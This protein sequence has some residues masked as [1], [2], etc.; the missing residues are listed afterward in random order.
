MKTLV[1]VV[2]V[3]VLA[4]CTS[5]IWSQGGGRQGRQG[6]Q[7]GQ[8]RQ[9]GPGG[10]G[11]PG[12]MSCPAMALAPPQA[13]MLERLTATLELTDEQVEELGDVLT[14]GDAAAKPLQQKAAKATLALRTALAAAEFDAAKVKELAIAAQKTETALIEASIDEWIQIR[15]IISST[16]VTTLQKSMTPP[17]RGL[18][19]QGGP[20]PEG[21]P[22]GPPPGAEDGPPSPEGGF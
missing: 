3:L 2:T 17:T 18:R 22:D 21:R 5:A 13:V 15:A 20:P 19:G 14:K 6:T 10:P 9:G 16:Q 7:G 11:G 4:I 1:L 8:G 12:M